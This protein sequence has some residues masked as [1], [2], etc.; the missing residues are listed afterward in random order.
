MEYWVGNLYK[1]N[2]TDIVERNK[3][4]LK[5][6]KIGKIVFCFG[7]FIAK[8]NYIYQATIPSE[9]KPKTNIRIQGQIFNKEV[10]SSATIIVLS[11]GVIKTTNS[12]GNNLCIANIAWETN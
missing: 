8:D 2:E 4:F 12:Y 11:D 1:I 7:T 6:Y 3:I 9:F 5:L 10:M